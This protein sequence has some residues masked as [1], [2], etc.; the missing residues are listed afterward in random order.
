M[1]YVGATTSLLSAS[2]GDNLSYGLKHRPLRQ[3]EY[4]SSVAEARRRRAIHEAALSG[5]STD[6]RGADWID[7]MATGAETP[8]SLTR[9]I[10]RAMDVA[11]LSPDVYQFGLRG[12]ID[13]V[14][15]PDAANRVLEAR[16]TLPSLLAQANLSDL[17]EP[18]HPER[19][20]L[21][22]TMGE[23]LLFGTP[24]GDEF[25]LDRLA[26]NPYV[27]GVLDKTGLTRD[28]LAMGFD[29]A[30]TMIELFA[31]LPPEHEYFAQFSFISFDDLPEFQTL[32]RGADAGNLD[33]LAKPDRLRL[34][35]LPFKL[36]PARH[37]LGNIDEAFQARL[38]TARKAFAEGLP[39]AYRQSIAFFAPDQYN[40]LA[41]LQDNIL[42]GKLVYGKAHA[43]Q[44]I[45]D[46][47]AELVAALGLREI[48][49]EAGLDFPAG[50][51]GTRLTAVQRQKV[52][53]ARAVL[54]RPD[55]LILNESTAS[56]DGP[57]QAHVLMSLI[58][59]FAGRTLIWALHRPSLA[60][61]FDHVIVMKS[62]RAAQ[63]GSFAEIGAGDGPLAQLIA[64]E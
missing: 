53:L 34:L 38:L 64:A 60:R 35:S 56:F 44:K 3:V 31:D 15:K 41:T 26:D 37:R 43:A 21:N 30:Q 13:P 52:A 29:V 46:I 51:G 17:I 20:N 8:H 32:M 42:F 57:S 16:A 36:I 48:V 6:D 28:L 63:Q 5:N 45:G 25:A 50:I 27:L 54:K 23:N 19:Y 47:I 24:R 39:E 61:Q 22:A 7:Y 58:E 18:F 1:T 49:I 10:V 14:L 40:G 4:A 59:E 55:I 12:T 11:D 2:L 33:R 9:E 62:G